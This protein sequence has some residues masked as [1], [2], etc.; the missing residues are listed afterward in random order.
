MKKHLLG[1]SLLLVHQLGFAQITINTASIP[2]AG[3]TFRYSNAQITAAIDPIPTGANFNWDFSFLNPISQ[4]IDTFRT[5]TSTGTT[6]ALFFA[7]VSF[8][9]NRSNQATRGNLGVPNAPIGGGVSISDVLA[10]YYKSNTL[11]QQTGYGATIN[12][13]GVPVGFNNK[14]VLY[15][16]PMNFGDTDTSA[17]DFN[18]NIPNLGYYGHEQVRVSEVDGWGSLTTPFG[19]FNTLRIKSTITGSDTLFLDTLGFGFSFPVN[20]IEYKWLGTTKSIPLLQ[21]VAS[22][23]PFGGAPQVSSVIFRD[24]VRTLTSLPESV[25]SLGNMSVFPNPVS[26]W[27]TLSVNS[28]VDGNAT[29]TLYAPDGRVVSNV[30]N[31]SLYAG[32]N[33]ISINLSTQKPANGIYFLE[34]NC[35]GKTSKT[36]LMIAD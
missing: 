5:V 22:S 9:S 28:I 14:D 23:G 36:R 27:V 8:N 31:G 35:G 21:I 6:Y 4:D 29:V 24:S 30:W 15:R 13:I 18:I 10:F 2:V 12:G 20:S 7:D 32:D 19:T 33:I 3:D 11:Y 16:F 1:F 34:L 17:S 26:D 25:L